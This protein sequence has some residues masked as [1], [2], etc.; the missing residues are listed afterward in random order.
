MNLLLVTGFLGAGKTTLV[1][2]LAAAL[3][4]R[5]RR[6]AIVVN[7]LGEVGIDD[8]L[9]RRLGFNVWE[10]LNGCICCTLSGDLLNTLYQLDTDYA[11]DVVLV[12]PTGAADPR[13]VLDALPLYRGR[14]LNVTVITLL[15]PLRLP[16]LMEVLTPLITS[17][18][19]RAQ[20]V[21]IGK[22]DLATDADI[23]FARHT[24]AELRPDIPVLVGH[25][26]QPATL[27]ALREHLPWLSGFSNPTPPPSAGM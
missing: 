12:E 3:A 1:L 6:A 17:Q 24:V 4:E 2:N 8:Q 27:D 13:N 26:A 19:Q 22:A 5:G 21:L 15:D 7:E 25:A 23:D 16:L 20:L 14:P 10:L 18:I 9:M 11:P